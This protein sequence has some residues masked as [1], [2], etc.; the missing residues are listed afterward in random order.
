MPQNEN[1]RVV[2]VNDCQIQTDK[3]SNSNGK[4]KMKYLSC[5]F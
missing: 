5:L 4:K 3:E 1:P 2:T